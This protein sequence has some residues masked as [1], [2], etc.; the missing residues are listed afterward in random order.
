VQDDFD[1]IAFQ[2]DLLALNASLEAARG[3]DA[4]KKFAQQAESFRML[5]RDI[6]AGNQSP[7]RGQPGNRLRDIE[8]RLENLLRQQEKI[9]ALAVEIN[10]N[11][12]SA[13]D[14]LQFEDVV[15]QVVVYSK[16]NAYSLRAL[17]SRID[18]GRQA[19]AAG[20][21]ANQDDI[22]SLTES[23]WRQVEALRAE[24]DLPGELNPAGPCRQ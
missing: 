4:G 1:Q 12:C 7:Q 10:D 11:S 17:A 24:S 3:G 13:T 18:L 16:E 8:K 9:S 2:C 22:G 14:A 19:I 20:I 21:T 15:A 23:F 5:S 6:V